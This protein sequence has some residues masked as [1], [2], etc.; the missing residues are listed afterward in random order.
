MAM[1]RLLIYLAV[2]LYMLSDG[3]VRPPAGA[4]ATA[5]SPQTH[6]VLGAHSIIR[7]MTQNSP[8]H[9]G[10]IYLDGTQVVVIMTHSALQCPTALENIAAAERGGA[11]VRYADF[12]YDG[13]RAA[14]N[15]LRQRYGTDCPVAAS[16]RSSS[17]DVIANRV[18]LE[19]LVYNDD[20]I[21]YFN[22][23]IPNPE[24]FILR[25]IKAD[26]LRVVAEPLRRQPALSGVQME[27]TDIDVGRHTLE[28]TLF[29]GSPYD[30]ATGV[31]YTVEYFDGINWRLEPGHY[32]FIYV[33]IGVP[34]GIAWDF[35]VN[36]EG[37]VGRLP[38]G[39]Y[40]IRKT[41]FIDNQLSPD[42]EYTELT[43]EFWLK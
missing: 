27:I 13:L 10:G 14:H 19:L 34:P 25:N 32:M 35:S 2:A 9:Y 1:I 11:I 24:M 21:A 37:T 22:E 3:T 40:R 29:N 15:S 41:V 12:T 31:A 38:S 20:I 8:E 17:V 16:V 30:I 5:A 18:V 26:E 39:R 33:G 4:V 43:A 36:L 6:A 42:F 23:N 28:M 7:M